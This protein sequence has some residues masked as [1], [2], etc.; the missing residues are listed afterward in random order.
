VVAGLWIVY[1]APDGDHIMAAVGT[2]ERLLAAHKG[3]AP[4]S[5]TSDSKL[6]VCAEDREPSGINFVTREIPSGRTV[7]TVPVDLDPSLG[8][9]RLSMH[10]DGNRVAATVGKIDYDLWIME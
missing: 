4:C 10:P 9:I 3:F 7:R 8:M 1:T 2:G 5:F 6:D